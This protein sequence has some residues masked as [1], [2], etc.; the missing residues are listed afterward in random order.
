MHWLFLAAILDFGFVQFFK[1]GE[2]RGYYGPVVVVAN[3]FTVAATIGTYLLFTDQWT[4][5]EG[6]VET[7]LVTGVLF[8]S[9][10][11]LMNHALTI[12]PVGSVLSAFRI[13]IIVPVFF[14]VYLW[15]EP[16]ASAQAVGLLLALLAL[17]LM[18]PRSQTH[19][20][21]TGIRA[22]GLL[23]LICFWQGLSHTSLRSVHYKGLDESFLQVLMLTGL[24]SGL[25]G[26]AFILLKKLRPLLP[27][28]KLGIFIGAYNAVALCVILTALSKL[29]G[30]L[31]FPALGCSVVLFDNLF[32]HFY[33]REPL[34]RPAMAG[35][36]IAILAL[37]LV[38]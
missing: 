18:T 34:N 21:F 28:V 7:G 17:V 14:G 2:R 13:A 32:A 35:V 8:I 19:A 1:L 37:A 5:A 23:A 27:E 31:F 20:R 16:L 38:V 25:I 9:S 30:T 10:M 4:F 6:T 29:P 22:F 11:L 3:Y 12:A 36:G 24:T 33:W 26:T 15:D